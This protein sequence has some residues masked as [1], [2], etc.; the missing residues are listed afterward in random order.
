MPTRPTKGDHGHAD[1]G[2]H[3]RGRQ[4]AVTGSTLEPDVA[5]ERMRQEGVVPD[6]PAG[7]P[8]AKPGPAGSKET[9]ATAS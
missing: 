4:H 7:D 3:G 6:S 9:G 2:S 1:S 8:D 5:E